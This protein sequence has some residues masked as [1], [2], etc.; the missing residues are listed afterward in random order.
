MKVSRRE[1]VKKLGI[2]SIAA[3][4]FSKTLFAENFIDP[5]KG[6][7]QTAGLTFLFQG[8]SITD[9]NRTRNND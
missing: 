1:F 5:L 6:A 7:N 8:D 4:S 2:G 9:G 3:M